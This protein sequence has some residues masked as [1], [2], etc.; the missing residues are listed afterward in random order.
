MFLITL[1]YIF[2]RVLN[3]A[4]DYEAAPTRSPEEVQK[5]AEICNSKKY[6]AKLAGDDSINLYFMQF[7]QSLRSR[8]MAAA[9]LGIYDY[10]LEVVL[11]ETG[12]VIKVHYKVKTFEP[13]VKCT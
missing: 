4:L 2:Y 7:L 12:Q 8:A 11:I 10:N 13:I 6:S 3:A 9:V 5:I 1:T